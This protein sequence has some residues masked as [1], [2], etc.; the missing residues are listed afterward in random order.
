MLLSATEK[1]ATGN[2]ARYV[3]VGGVPILNRMV[4][5]GPIKI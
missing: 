4:G 1:N 3:G 5:E 2:G